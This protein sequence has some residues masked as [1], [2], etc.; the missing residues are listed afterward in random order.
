MNAKSVPAIEFQV[1]V[2]LESTKYAVYTDG[3]YLVGAVDIN[4]A[5]AV[6]VATGPSICRGEKRP[7]SVKPASPD[8]AVLVK[9]AIR[10]VR[11][12]TTEGWERE[13]GRHHLGIEPN[14]TF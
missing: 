7:W 12:N 4:D 1:E 11:A 9:V 3:Y 10:D 13:R 5:E 2:A 14:A 6:F 8:G